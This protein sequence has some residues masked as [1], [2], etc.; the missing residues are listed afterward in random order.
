MNVDVL[1]LALESG[2][3]SELRRVLPLLRS[4]SKEYL[5]EI[6][7]NVTLWPAI[8]EWA[9]QTREAVLSKEESERLSSS[10]HCLYAVF[11]LSECLKSHAFSFE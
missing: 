4:A 3:G 8:A 10:H 1:L 7:G 6:A 2:K 5:A 9:R 11:V